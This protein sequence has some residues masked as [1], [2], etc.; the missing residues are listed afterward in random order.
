[1]KRKGVNS[2]IITLILVVSSISWGISSSLVPLFEGIDGISGVNEI[3]SRPNILF[4]LTDD[5]AFSTIGALGNTRI[6]TPTM[7]GLVTEG[8]HFTNAYVMG[9][10]S[11][12][13]CSPSRAM[14]FSGRTLWN[15]ENQGQYGFEISAAYQ[16]LF[17]VFLENGYNTFATG[18]NEP[19]RDGHFARSFNHAD[20]VLFRGMTGSQYRLPL[21]SFSPEGDYSREREEIHTGTHSA[22]VY[23]DAAIRFIE[24]QADSEVPFVAYVAFQTPHDPRQAPEEFQAKYSA[25]EMVLP[26]SYLPQ[27][28]FDNGMLQ[29]RDEQ[30]AGFPRTPDEIKQHIAD[31][32]AMVSHDD[33]Q[34]SRI[35]N[36]LKRSGKYE[37]TIIV[38]TSDNGLAVGKHGLMGKQNLYEH[39]IRVPLILVGPGIPKGEQRNHL[40][41]IYDLNPT[42]CELAGIPVPGS[43]QFKS[44]ADIIAD[45]TRQHR[46]YLYFAFMY[47]Q[48]AVRNERFKL[49]EYSVE[50]KRHTQLFDLISDREELHNLAGNPEFQQEVADLREL[51]LGEKDSQNDGNS[52]SEFATGQGTAF[53]QTY[54][55]VKTSEVPQP[56]FEN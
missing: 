55:N 37:K 56:S 30:L 29:I 12:A 11:P 3:E 40:C 53:W 39:S 22:E 17:Q 20:K 24:E 16:T 18:K 2:Q 7:D 32:Y 52:T 23:A 25:D 33:F 5:Q 4:I 36:A 35:L 51:L 8:T 10:S 15:L 44:M 38:F 50:E 28:P 49:V 45:P 1:M 34:I 19:G 42:L 9:G 41:Y 43:V 27:H 54:L 14:L 6:Q 48:R 46:D 47:W 26:A 13:I 31:Y 21:V